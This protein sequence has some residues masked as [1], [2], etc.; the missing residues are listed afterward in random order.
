[1]KE[2]HF[3]LYVWLWGQ[4]SWCYM[5][6]HFLS[7]CR[8]IFCTTPPPKKK[9]FFR[10]IWRDGV[11]LIFFIFLARQLVIL[12]LLKKILKSS[13]KAGSEHRQNKHNTPITWP[14]VAMTCNVS[15][16]TLINDHKALS[17]AQIILRYNNFWYINIYTVYIN[18]YL[19]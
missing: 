4:C 2:H 6:L 5:P 13:V 1:M 7:R 10:H 3:H 17:W 18:I 15:F 16:W 11:L 12:D 9:L 8:W 14:H 19:L